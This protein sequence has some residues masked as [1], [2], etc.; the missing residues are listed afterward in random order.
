MQR[1]E[2][3]PGLSGAVYGQ[4]V[5]QQGIAACG[6]A[7]RG[8]GLAC[9]T[10]PPSCSRQGLK[11]GVGTWRCASHSF[12]PDW[13]GALLGHRC[14]PVQVFTPPVQAFPPKPCLRCLQAASPTTER[15]RQQAAAPVSPARPPRRWASSAPAPRLKRRRQRPKVGEG[16]ALPAASSLINLHPLLLHPRVPFAPLSASLP[17]RP[18]HLMRLCLRSRRLCCIC[19]ASAAPCCCIPTTTGAFPSYICC[20]PECAPAVS[21]AAHGALPIVSAMSH[22]YIPTMAATFLVLLCWM[23]L[24]PQCVLLY[25]PTA[26]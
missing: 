20:I 26:S 21:G 16:L 13:C 12:R 11:L 4:R 24:I 1:A 19:A 8:T 18:V 7:Q 9:C 6:F 5:P 17:Y 3:V 2:A 14:L 25:I 15:F 22:W 10:R 23:C